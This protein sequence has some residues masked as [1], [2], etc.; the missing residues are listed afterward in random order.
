MTARAKFTEAQ[1]VAVL[2]AARK[3]DPN[4]QILVTPEG[5]RTIAGDAPAPAEL[6][7]FDMLDMTAK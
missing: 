6:D 7:E 3:V 4:A 5:I 2:R 1:I